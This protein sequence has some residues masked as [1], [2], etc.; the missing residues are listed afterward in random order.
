MITKV[1]TNVQGQLSNPNNAQRI[2]ALINECIR[3][4]QFKKT[5]QFNA[6]FY[7][8]DKVNVKKN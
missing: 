7:N 1:H 3:N 2:H 8:Y 5:M 6:M 4:I